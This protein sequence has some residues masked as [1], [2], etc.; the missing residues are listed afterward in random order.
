[1]STTTPPSI[2]ALTDLG[3]LLFSPGEHPNFIGLRIAPDLATLRAA[4]SA[5]LHGK[6]ESDTL[7]CCC[8]DCDSPGPDH[9]FLLFA[10]GHFTRATV[11]H[12]CVHAAALFINQHVM[13]SA[14]VQ[15]MSES[16]QFEYYQEALAQITERLFAQADAILYPF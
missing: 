2:A 16:E 8:F 12:E 5:F 7:A 11:V 1:M 9:G 3:P 14:A 10:R 13:H 15:A 4:E 6:A